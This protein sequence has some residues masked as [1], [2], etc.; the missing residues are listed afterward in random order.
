[1]APNCRLIY[2]FPYR[3]LMA[4][5]I[6]TQPTS[7]TLRVYRVIE[8]CMDLVQGTKTLGLTMSGRLLLPITTG[9]IDNSLLMRVPLNKVG[10]GLFL[11]RHLKKP[12]PL[13]WLLDN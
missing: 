3:P 10:L 5:V 4:T 7:I 12:L 8:M 11:L 6:I 2:R 9:I 1:M 13:P